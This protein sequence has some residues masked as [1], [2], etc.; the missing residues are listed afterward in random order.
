MKWS[1]I[2]KALGLADTATLDEVKKAAEA[3]NVVIKGKDGNVDLDAAYKA[4]TARTVIVE[5]EVEANDLAVKAAAQA[6]AKADRIADASATKLN[7]DGVPQRFAIGGDAERKAFN[8]RAS[9]GETMVSD[10]DTA[11]YLGAMFRLM[12]VKSKPELEDMPVVKRDREIVGKDALSYQFATGGFAVPEAIL[13]PQLVNIRQ[14]YDALAALGLNF[15]PLAPR[16]EALPRRTAGVTVFSPSEGVAATDSQPSGDQVILKPFEMVALAKVSLMQ[17][18]RSAIEYGN[19]IVGEMAYA[20]NKKFE[21]IVILG[22]GTSTYFNQIGLVGRFIKTITDAGGTWATNVAFNSGIK[23]A[24]GNLF[25][26]FTY[27][28][29]KDTSAAMLDMEGSNERR[30]LTNMRVHRGTMEP[31]M[32]NR[33]G[34]T[35]AEAANGLRAPLFDGDTVV[36]SNAMPA[37]DANSQFAAFYG[38]F[39]QGIKIGEV[40]GALN[41]STDTSRYWDQRQVGYQ[42]A[43]QRAVAVHDV[44]IANSSAA[45]R[46]PGPITALVS[47]AS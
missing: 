3:Q 15:I 31:L 47:A 30:W 23:V 10:A 9:R 27:Q 8:A 44:G 21:E 17:L 34:T 18:Q 33:G 2:C 45:S 13:R 37:T 38:D 4:H 46:L 32:S 43:V 24:T 5:D 36:Y 42:F 7:D 26:E 20:I 11:E 25:S 14:R 39:A 35:Y 6:K 41:V 22:D 1:T 40:S 29:F 19:F 28:D 16:G 12:A